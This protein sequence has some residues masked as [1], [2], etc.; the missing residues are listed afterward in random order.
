MTEMTPPESFTSFKCVEPQF[1]KG[2]RVISLARTD[3][4]WAG[5]QYVREGGENNL[6]S[7]SYMDGVYFVTKGRA[8][9][10][11][12]NDVVLGEVGANEGMVITRGYRYWF[13]SCGDETLE[14]L[15]VQ[16]FDRTL[17]SQEEVDD[18]R[19]D[20]VV[21]KASQLDPELYA[22]TGMS[23]KRPA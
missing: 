22:E 5:M 3:R 21:K 7:H 8:R 15:L 18:D 1:T 11:G 12:E 6:H 19:I 4:L 17:K 9:F 16:C 23:T 2:K 10:Y 14:L 13:E 20:H